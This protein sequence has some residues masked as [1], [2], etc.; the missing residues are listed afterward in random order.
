MDAGQRSVPAQSLAAGRV[1]PLVGVLAALVRRFNETNLVAQSAALAFY[2]LLSLA[3]LLLIL[4]WITA[5]AL[6]S[7]RDALLDQVG[8]LLGHD[9]GTVA[10]AVL[11]SAVSKPNTGSIAGLW[12]MGLLLFGATA[13][14]GQLQSA[15]NQIFRTNAKRLP[16]VTAWLRKRIFSFGM[17][18]AVG[19][20]LLVSM[21][22]QTL[23]QLTFAHLAWLLPMV[24]SIVTW[25][26]YALAFALMFHYL[27]DRRVGWRYAM[28]GGVI[29]AS[30]F[31]LGRAA[32]GWYLERSNPGAAYGAMGALVL[33]LIWVYYAGLIVF[34]G[35]LVTAMINERRRETRPTPA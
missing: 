34:V 3:P 15:L 18:L 28:V 27:P 20:L 1:H 14:F 10:D 7:A 9:F 23:L 2:A 21:T 24:G 26:I 13:V 35:A 31:V 32:I 11:T 29:T 4:L 22:V 12:S 19:F 17:V 25:L 33:T 30:L 6:P 16:G 5:A 8:S